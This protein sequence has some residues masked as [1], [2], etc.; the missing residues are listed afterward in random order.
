MQPALPRSALHLPPDCCPFLGDS[1]D[2]PNAALLLSPRARHA[3]LMADL[4]GL[5][6]SSRAW[7]LPDTTFSELVQ[8]LGQAQYDR[9]HVT[10]CLLA[11]CND[12]AQVCLQSQGQAASASL[13]R[14]LMRELV[15]C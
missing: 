10:P 15:Q 14:P 6:S 9:L 1:A 4:G 11:V 3:L 2:M 8:P 7:A 12:S 13:A 5:Q